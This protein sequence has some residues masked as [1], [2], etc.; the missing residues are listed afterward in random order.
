LQRVGL[1][2]MLEYAD[3]TR[4]GLSAT[5]DLR[6]GVRGE[7]QTEHDAYQEFR[8]E[9][10]RK[11]AEVDRM[12]A[13]LRAIDDGPPARRTSDGQEFRRQLRLRGAR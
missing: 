9:R 13:R 10:H 7:R 4:F 3:G 8:F 12:L 1:D 6:A 2:L 11:D 5:R